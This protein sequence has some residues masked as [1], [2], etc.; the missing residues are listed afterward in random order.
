[1]SGNAVRHLRSDT[2]FKV[3]AIALTCGVVIGWMD[4]RPGWDDTGVSAGLIVLAATTLVFLRPRYWWLTLPC[5]VAP[6]VALNWYER[7]HPRAETPYSELSEV[8]ARNY[9]PVFEI[10]L[11]PGEGVPMVEA[12]PGTIPLRRIPSVT[13][14]VFDTIAAAR[15][16]RLE[17]DSTR[18]QTIEPAPVTARTA[19][20]IR[21]RLLGDIR[22]L[23]RTQYYS[24]AFRQTVV[25]LQAGDRFEFLQYRAEGSCFLRVVGNVIE[26][27]PCP[28]HDT[29]HFT[30]RTEPATR[31]WIRVHTPSASG[32]L[33]LADSTARIARR[34]RPPNPSP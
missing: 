28:T 20:T 10:E 1:M 33:L 3:A 11:S 2:P 6:V 22:Y 8:P 27:D 19:A 34:M 32:W 30:A 13:A 14:P 17:F 9:E 7:A 31:W 12:V 21:G 16:R 4:T 24:R 29:T 5:I 26:A 18:Y 23:S 15:V 25:P